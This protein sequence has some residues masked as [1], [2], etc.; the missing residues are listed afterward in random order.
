MKKV[1]GYLTAIIGFIMILFSALNYILGWNLQTA[2]FSVVGI[3]CTVIG[4]GIVK[5]AKLHE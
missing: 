5:K 2:S 1:F 4:M 3:V